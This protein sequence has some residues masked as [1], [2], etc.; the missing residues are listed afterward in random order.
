MKTKLFIFLLAIFAVA[1]FGYFDNK[2]VFAT[3][4]ADS[5][6]YVS[7]GDSIAVGYNLPNY[8]KD[9]SDANGETAGQFVQDSYA[10]KFKTLLENKYGANNVKSTTYATS[11]DAGADLLEKLENSTIQNTLK[12]ADVVTICI[13]ANDILGP[14]LDNISGYILKDTASGSVSIAQMENKLNDG[15]QKF[16]GTNNQQGIFDKILNKLYELNSDAEY[17]FTNIYNPYKVFALPTNLSSFIGYTSFSEEKINKMG[18]ITNV[19]LAGGK[20]SQDQTVFGLNQ[21]LQS[22][23]QDFGKGNF[24]LVDTF[25]GFDAHTLTTI[26]KYNELVYATLTKDSVIDLTEL[27]NGGADVIMSKTDPH[28]TEKGHELLY[29]AF[30]AFFE[31]N[32]CTL[33]LE[34]NGATINNKTSE[35]QLCFKNSKP[36]LPQLSLSGKIFGGWYTSNGTKWT[37]DSKITADTVLYAKWL[38][39]ITYNLNGGENNVNNPNGYASGETVVLQNATKTGYTFAGWFTESD[40]VNQKQTILGDENQNLVPM[41]L[42][43]HK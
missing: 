7:L 30:S 15:L 34:Y 13:G 10:Y 24:V 14:A 5:I 19:Y 36:N 35:S 26:P 21:I 9:V 42:H 37:E 12:N 38:Y 27:M 33:T 32:I 16:S 2:I 8:D 40:F 31:N 43:L 11:G 1:S 39:S 3:E 25:S 6:C 41:V 20:N 17:I 23:I 28:P 4:S 18:E 29:D 22:K